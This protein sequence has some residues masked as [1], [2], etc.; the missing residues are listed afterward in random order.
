MSVEHEI[1]PALTVRLSSMVSFMA[2]GRVF[3]WH[4]VAPDVPVA[5]TP[6]D[7]MREG[8]DTAMR[9]AVDLARRLV[10]EGARSDR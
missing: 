5:L 9:C 10:A 1:D 3:D 2:D 4:G 8:E 7:F 6:Q